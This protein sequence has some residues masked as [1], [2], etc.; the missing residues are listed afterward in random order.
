MGR[1]LCEPQKNI[2]FVKEKLTI[3]F[4]QGILESKD[5]E[6][7]NLTDLCSQGRYALTEFLIERGLGKTDNID[8]DRNTLLHLAAAYGQKSLLE[9]VLSKCPEQVNAQN[10]NGFIPLQVF[11]AKSK[12]SSAEFSGSILNLWKESGVSDLVPVALSLDAQRDSSCFS[13]LATTFPTKTGEIAIGQFYS[14]LKSKKLSPENIKQCINNNPNWYIE[15]QKIQT[16]R[17]E[18]PM[19]L[20]LLQRREY[21][22]INDLLKVK[23]P[24]E[25]PVF[26][27]E[28]A[29][30]SKK[31]GLIDYLVRFGNVSENNMVT[32]LQTLIARSPQHEGEKSP[33]TLAYLRYVNSKDRGMLDTLLKA[34]TENFKWNATLERTYEDNRSY[35]SSSYASI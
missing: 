12:N 29:I 23:T 7:V 16:E 22:I 33:L 26:D 24:D 30:D 17:Q 8:K 11:I 13:S 28:V 15:A 32:L 21:S 10:S 19:L 9:K 35:T 27:P 5:L 31:D 14:L 2:T 3:L 18:L 6:S 4:E 1:A 25:K 34:N 20:E